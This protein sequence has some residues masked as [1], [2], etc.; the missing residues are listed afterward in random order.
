M[1]NFSFTPS[2]TGLEGQASGYKVASSEG[3]VCHGIGSQKGL[4]HITFAYVCLMVWCHKNPLCDSLDPIFRCQGYELRGPTISPH[5]RSPGAAG[6]AGGKNLQR[7]QTASL[8]KKNALSRKV[9]IPMFLIFKSD[10]GAW[11]RIG[12]VQRQRQRDAAPGSSTACTLQG[13]E[14]SRRLEVHVALVARLEEGA[15]VLQT[16]SKLTE[17]MHVDTC[18]K[19]FPDSSP[20]HKSKIHTVSPFEQLWPLE[21]LRSQ[22]KVRQAGSSSASVDDKCPAHP[23]ISVQPLSQAVDSIPR[24]LHFDLGSSALRIG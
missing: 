9:W 13:Q 19:V 17:T 18:E 2:D 3:S 16:L 24:C 6:W 4:R 1:R 10:G 23:D 7:L 22:P 14:A 5:P 15:K 8:Y 11:L 20:S 21:A 12:A